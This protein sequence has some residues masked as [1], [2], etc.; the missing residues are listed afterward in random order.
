MFY[1]TELFRFSKNNLLGQILFSFLTIALV[2]TVSNYDSF[3]TRISHALP[4]IQNEYYFN[5]LVD[6]DLNTNSISRKISGL[7]GVKGIEAISATKSLAVTNQLKDT[8]D[9]DKQEITSIISMKGLKVIL[10]EKVSSSSIDLIREYLV[11][12]TGKDHVVLGAVRKK[13]ANNQS[14]KEVMSELKKRPLQVLITVLALFWSVAF[15]AVKRNLRQISYLIEK[16]QRKKNVAVKMYFT[17]ILVSVTL[18]CGISYAFFTPDQL[19]AIIVCVALLATS[20]WYTIG[21]LEWQRA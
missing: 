3:K 8:L 9:L 16:F 5:A 2:V 6:G 19:L 18:G 13:I 20:T 15:L 14:W 17:N 21:K 12:L 10:D 1:L 4:S 7:P 11:R